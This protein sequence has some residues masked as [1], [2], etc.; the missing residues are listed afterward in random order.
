[1]TGAL[2]LLSLL[3]LVPYPAAGASQPL[4]IQV[5]HVDA[6][7]QQPFPPFLRFFEYADFFSR[8]VRVHQGDTIDFQAQPFS[9]HVVALAANRDAALR[10]Y[11]AVLPDVDRDG[12]DVAVGSGLPKIIEGPSNNPIVG[13]STHGGGTIFADHGQG[14]PVCGVAARGQAPC[15][16]AGGDDVEVIGPTPGFGPAGPATID[17]YVKIN[18]PVGT[19]TYFDTVH[20]GM[21]G[22]LQVVPASQPASTQTE[23]DTA[24]V[25]QFQDDQ[26]QALA[27]EKVLNQ[28]PEGVGPPGYRQFSVLVG[29]SAAQNHVEIDEM[30]PKKALNLVPGDAVNFVWADAQGNHTVAFPAESPYVPEPFGYDCGPNSPGYMPVPPS[31]N[32][33]VPPGCLEPGASAGEI[34][35]NPGNAG[36]GTQLTR[37]DVVVD[38]GMR[39]GAAF[40]LHPSSQFWRATTGASTQ[41][42]PY[43]FSCT[44]HDWMQGTLVVGNA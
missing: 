8:S 23:I 41:A 29:A 18:A 35:G 42:G 2:L 1:L 40:N 14:P 20:P 21:Q 27:V 37:P 43:S 11:P 32:L 28:L 15:L 7:N 16:F 3:A 24:S 5:D 31:V 10:A 13:G 22:T 38:A 34:I 19:Y 17:Q 4:V 26:A 12:A 30:F 36:S 39:V 6:A 9:F 25:L 33:P 44:V